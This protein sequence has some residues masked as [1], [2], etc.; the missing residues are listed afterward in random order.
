ML[1]LSGVLRKSIVALVAAQAVALGWVLLWDVTSPGVAARI[2]TGP[3]AVVI[4]L[5]VLPLLGWI[6]WRADRD[7]M[8]EDAHRRADSAESNRAIEIKTV[9]LTAEALPARTVGELRTTGS[10]GV[11][12]V[13]RVVHVPRPRTAKA[14]DAAD[15]RAGS[16]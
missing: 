6:A 9:V 8:R 2:A 13:H 11:V 3:L 12:A 7:Q 16:R 4:G 1:R 5:Q 14:A 10:P 15:R